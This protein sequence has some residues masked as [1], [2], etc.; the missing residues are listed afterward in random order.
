MG[1]LVFG[2][3]KAYQQLFLLSLILMVASCGG[4][5]SSP[6][7]QAPPLP[8]N[9]VDI[10]SY[11]EATCAIRAVDS[12]LAGSIWCWGSNSSSRLGDPAII[13]NE[14]LKPL[15]IDAS[16]NWISVSIG[17][18]HICAVSDIGNLYCRGFN[19]TG[20]IG[21]PVKT[22]ASENIYT[23]FLQIGQANDWQSVAVSETH[24]CAI[25]VGGAVYCWGSNGSGQL[26]SDV[27]ITRTTQID[28][29]TQIFKGRNANA[30]IPD[31]S[32]WSKL[33]TSSTFTCGI[34]NEIISNQAVK[35]AW[36]WGWS[37]AIGNNVI[38]NNPVLFP[39]PVV[40]SV[41]EPTASWLDISTGANH[42][43][44][45]IES[46][47]SNPET[48][49]GSLWCWGGNSDGQSGQTNLNDQIFLN[50]TQ[51]GTAENWIT[52]SAGFY[53]SCAVNTRNRMFCWG[54]NA[55][56]Q[57]G[58]LGNDSISQP[59]LVSNL[60]DQNWIAVV[61]G[62]AHDCAVNQS[63]NTEN[64]KQSSVRCW[65]RNLFGQ[66]GNGTINLTTVPNK[67]IN[68]K[69]ITDDPNIWAQLETGN[70]HSCAIKTDGTLW[71]WG[72]N[73]EGQL[74]NKNTSSNLTLNQEAR[75]FSDWSQVSSY[76][77]HNCALRPNAT[78]TG[79][80]L[81]CWGD[82]RNGQLGGEF[83]TPA[84]GATPLNIAIP[85]LIDST[86]TNWKQLSV[87]SEF[88][89]ALKTD[90]TYWCWGNNAYGKLAT[91]PAD[92]NLPFR[93]EQRQAIQ[94][95]LANPTNTAW[96]SVS[97]GR[98]SQCGI[99][100]IDNALYCWGDNNYEQ[101]GSKS[102]AQAGSTELYSAKP[103]QVNP[104][105]ITNSSWSSVSMGRRHACA[106]DTNQLLWCWGDT[107]NGAIGEETV[108]DPLATQIV[109][110]PPIQINT[111]E[112]SNAGVTSKW[113]LISVHNNMSC[114]LKSDN[115]L[116][117]WG[118]N[119]NGEIGNGNKV[120]SPV[121]VNVD[122]GLV[123]WQTV[124]ASDNH[125]CALKSDNS[126][127]CW[128]DNGDGELGNSNTF[129]TVPVRALIP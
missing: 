106:I 63:L 54:R 34:K 31:D 94:V 38:N 85:T 122:S 17:F 86:V 56:V 15:Q 43:C 44:G 65:G 113:Q 28:T 70:H 114:A 2:T 102:A 109:T 91:Q 53:H 51:V 73:S 121:P 100:K 29:P 48:P 90:D 67:V 24:S 77:R 18:D 126:L 3:K 23:N 59:T 93:D 55:N 99:T 84:T 82:N 20:N 47:N 64:K 74:G 104:A 108:Y 12:S 79:N 19:R 69:A 110:T 50:P 71:C 45:I 16:S 41:T 14:V 36:C 127:W 92:I 9:I 78:N 42:A 107:S 103:L 98:N 35:S 6:L 1:I 76:G 96:A 62:R 75:L 89:C 123:N 10:T 5:S 30:A 33:S 57:L 125:T 58:Q 66:L 61:S 81:W 32:I 129:V 117:C 88:S 4:G 7:P 26:T 128:G 124:A 80:S 60:R 68:N 118:A 8:N 72:L 25:K 11:A 95:N 39:T 22:V 83:S 105:G 116:W 21:V 87:G 13:G 46:I 115:S 40:L 120:L 111:K 27:A 49:S 52:V 37:N 101:L 112:D 97:A 119:N